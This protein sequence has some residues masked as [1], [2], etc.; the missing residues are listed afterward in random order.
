MNPITKMGVVLFNGGIDKGAVITAANRPNPY[1]P[2]PVGQFMD[3]YG[4]MRQADVVWRFID[5]HASSMTSHY[6]SSYSNATVTGLVCINGQ[7]TKARYPDVNSRRGKQL[8]DQN[9]LFLSRIDILGLADMPNK[10]ND[11]PLFN[12]HCGG[13][14]TITNISNVNIRAGD[15]LIA[16][17]PRLDEIAEGGRRED[18]DN[19]GV[20]TLWLKPY[21]PSQ[22]QNTPRQIL[23][24]LTE[25]VD[26]DRK[27]AELS[28]NSFLPEYADQCDRLF[29]AI[30]NI[31]LTFTKWADNNGLAFNNPK[32]YTELMMRL[33]HQRNYSANPAA[34]DFDLKQSLI[35]TMFVTGFPTGTNDYNVH[36]KGASTTDLTKE[37]IVLNQCQRQ[38]VSLMLNEIARFIHTVTKNIV[39]KALTSMEP[40]KDGLFQHA[41]YSGCK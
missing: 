40:G 19:N 24:C 35:D 14:Q 27:G 18:A 13:T 20:I 1:Y 22:H 36:K 32:D 3:W 33:G 17:A 5:E 8:L 15:W 39:G 28:R 4:K 2:A 26:A 10:D 38:G 9:E 25:M 12:I 21:S 31:G 23:H 11:S 29:E 7:G 37:E 34:Q 41:S 6:N 30:V 16:Y